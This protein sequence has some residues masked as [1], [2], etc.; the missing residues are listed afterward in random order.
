MR[1]L[2]LFVLILALCASCLR[3]NYTSH[4]YYADKAVLSRDEAPH[5]KNSLEWWYLT[6]HL[7]DSATGE[8]FGI[9]YVF[10]HFNPRGGK[11]AMMVNVAITDPQRQQFYYDYRAKPLGKHLKPDLPIS[12]QMKKGKQHWTFYGQEGHYFADAMMHRHKGYG[13]RL[14][15]RPLKPVQLHHERGYETYGSITEAGYYSYPRLAATGELYIDGKLR[16]VGGELW[17]DRQW[18]CFAVGAKPNI[19]WDWISIQLDDPREEI[20]VYLLKD[21]ESGVQV[22][23]GSH[24]AADHT[25]TYLSQ[26]D[27][28]ITEVDH[29]QSPKSKSR[30]PTTWRVQI[31]KLGYD[32]EVKARMPEQELHLQFLPWLP[33]YYWEGMATATGT[34]YGKPVQGNS[35]V[36]ITNRT[37]L[38]KIARKQ[39]RQKK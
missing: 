27:I 20:M 34:Q 28:V 3:A 23:G 2:L 29:W 14:E 12:L 26:E 10:F 9:E 19:G 39:R 37:G 25:N 38:E 22:Y 4:D 11:D 1:N 18:N 16:K 6:G 31:E 32:L 24:F 33:F 21:Y 30:Y 17:Y 35:Y 15:T 5:F 7:T 36:E 13:F 8:E